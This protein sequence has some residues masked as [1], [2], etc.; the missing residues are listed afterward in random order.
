MRDLLTWQPSYRLASA[1]VAFLLPKKR[2]D[3]P[4]QAFASGVAFDECG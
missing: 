2:A 3:V 4:Q 1:D